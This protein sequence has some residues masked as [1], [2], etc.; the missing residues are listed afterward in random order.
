MYLRHLYGGAPAKAEFENR[1]RY[2]Y[3]LPL[4]LDMHVYYGDQPSFTVQPPPSPATLNTHIPAIELFGQYSSSGLV[5]AFPVDPA[6]WTLHTAA[7]NGAAE[8]AI[9]T[10]L[11]LPEGAVNAYAT[12]ASN[13]GIGTLVYTCV[14]YDNVGPNNVANLAL[15]ASQAQ[16]FVNGATSASSFVTG[17]LTFGSYGGLAGGSVSSMAA[18]LNYSP[19]PPSVRTRRA[20]ASFS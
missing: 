15:W 2:A 7:N 3:G 16:S 10:M 9:A 1:L 17:Y 19:P 20:R 18:S 5:V 6:V 13:N 11:G 8:K 12:S 4:G 14:F